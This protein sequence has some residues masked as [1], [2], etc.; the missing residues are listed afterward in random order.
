[1]R[2]LIVEDEASS[3]HLLT[4]FLK[5]YGDCTTTED[6]LEAVQAFTNALTEG[7]PFSLVCLDIKL[8]SMDGMEVLKKIRAMEEE[9]GILV[10][11]GVKIIMTTALNDHKKI[12]E[13][14]NAQAEV[15]LQKPINKQK[16]IDH[17]KKLNLI[18]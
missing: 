6:G 14:F 7:N 12:M 15:Y 3:R 11:D 17:M 9:M 18:K 5:P 16:L 1:M 13:A 2:I 8:P 4:S 10:G